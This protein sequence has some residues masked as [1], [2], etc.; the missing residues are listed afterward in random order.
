MKHLILCLMGKLP[1]KLKKMRIIKETLW[2][3]KK[4]PQV[5]G[6]KQC[7]ESAKRG[8]LRDSLK[9]HLSFLNI[10]TR[11]FRINIRSTMTMC[12]TWETER[13]SNK[14]LIIPKNGRE[15][16]I[17][18]PSRV[19]E[20]TMHFD[21]WTAIKISYK[22]GIVQLKMIKTLRLGRINFSQKGCVTQAWYRHQNLP[23]P[24]KM[25]LL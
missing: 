20:G 25:F 10:F 18:I 13:W 14:N 7:W 17:R 5:K 11:H 9:I 15:K 2:D 1:V 3:I 12:K 6:N 8:F 16:R 22:L 19:K 21:T 23:I 24:D 4:M